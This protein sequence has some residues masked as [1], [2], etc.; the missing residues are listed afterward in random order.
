VTQRSWLR[1]IGLRL[2]PLLQPTREQD[3]R[4]IERL[5]ANVAAQGEALQ[6]QRDLLKALRREVKELRTR[7]AGSQSELTARLDQQRLALAA[8]DDLRADQHEHSKRLQ[9][10]IGKQG[11]FIKGVLRNARH[12]TDHA[13]VQERVLARLARIAASGR[14]IVVGPWT[15]EVGFELVYWVPFVRWFV[16]HFAVDPS[17]LTIVSRGG[18]ATW[19]GEL[20]TR[21]VDVLE[22]M[23]P[24]ELGDAGRTRKQRQAGPKDRFV[25]R[26]VAERIGARPSVLHPLYLYGMCGAYFDGFAGVRPLLE[27]LRHRR[28]SA[29][30]RAAVPDLPERYVA[31]KFYFSASFPDTPENRAFA[32]RILAQVAEQLPV[33][34]L[35]HGVDVD[36]H[37]TY[38][39][40]HMNLSSVGARVTPQNNLDVQT[41]V[42]AGAAA[43]VGTYGGFAYLAPLCGVPALAFHS[44]PEYYL[45]HRQLADVTFS[46]LQ[47]PPLTVLSTEAA[48]LVTG[49]AGALAAA[50]RR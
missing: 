40:A 18:T 21:Y 4:A 41:A 32:D 47:L 3:H 27:L 34:V 5:A 36:D 11:A 10:A 43:F 13:V 48:R 28:I 50:D 20:A 15:G 31:A 49:L 29:P 22:L 9:T 37:R 39:G 33:V 17:R 35:E 25:I 42:V 19:Y 30:P 23:P 38:G 6:R 14:P 1:G 2:L 16:E 45:H 44:T 46:R 12:I 7:V 26:R 24:S 8:V